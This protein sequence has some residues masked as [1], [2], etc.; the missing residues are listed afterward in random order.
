[1]NGIDIITDK[2]REGMHQGNMHACIRDVGRLAGGYLASGAITA[3]ELQVA[4]QLCRGLAINPDQAQR[5]WDESVGHGTNEPCSP[6]MSAFESVPLALDAPLADFGMIRAAKTELEKTKMRQVFDTH[7]ME[8]PE[9]PVGWHGGEALA[10]YVD[11]L[12]GPDEFV[13]FSAESYE[14][15]GRRVPSKGCYTMTAGQITDQLT[16]MPLAHV[17]GDWDESAG[18]WI[19]FN[20]LDGE[21]VSDRN[22]TDYRHA[23]VES[24]S[25]PI[26]DQWAI[27]NALELPIAAVVS[28]GKKSIHAIVKINARDKSEYR[29]RVAHLYDV[30][31][32]HG[33]EIDKQN[34]NC[35]R[36]SRLP[37]ATRNGNPQRLLSLAMGKHSWQ[38]W[39]DWVADAQ[40]DLPDVESWDVDDD[41]RP[42]PAP[43]L[44][45]GTLRE[46]HKMMIAGPSKAGKSFLLIQLC[47][48]AATGTKW[49]GRNVAK[50]KALYVNLELDKTS[51]NCRLFDIKHKLGLK[52]PKGNLDVWHLRGNAVSLDKLAPKLIR[53]ARDA[54]YS[55]IVIDPLYKVLT[56]DE[57]SNSEMAEFCNYFD[58]IAN[59]L[60]C[61][62]VYCHHHSKGKQGHKS[63]N[64]RSSGAGVF[65]RDPDAVMDLIELE[66]SESAQKVIQE[67]WLCD[68][69]TAWL[70]I[71][72]DG[73]RANFPQDDQQVY[74][75]LKPW[76]RDEY[77]ASGALQMMPADISAWRVSG[78]LREFAR[79]E[80]VNCFF[81][82]PVHEIETTG[83]LADCKEQ[84]EETPIERAQR[85]KRQA[86]E[87]QKQD[88]RAAWEIAMAT[89]EGDVHLSQMAEILGCAVKTAR[90]KA[91]TYGYTV[92]DGVIERKA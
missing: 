62:I 51:S 19:R 45:E 12:F 90:R 77:P 53:R 91:T 89:I 65:A 58:Q 37:G 9:L 3:P 39:E 30:C 80:N 72:A 46:G 7:Y 21:G 41:E 4:A 63:S 43:E 13:G 38:A 73:W 81:R 24:D 67:R 66:V 68:E 82:W 74:R 28:S 25:V 75:K 56:G 44:I 14:Q 40:D 18:A 49:L 16:R 11:A 6:E 42:I 35:S 17:I 20:P 55:L 83:I 85:L 52:I 33:L 34:R 78:T 61:A 50:G 84:G 32:A 15:D 69:L 70:D 59:S 36:L 31:Q 86:A 23:L 2:L 71:N 26:A 57:N 1:M 54:K 27:I 64:D 87:Q 48:A 8:R 22:V 76:A 60:N 88:D 10:K 47:V 79:F 92:S 29:E 5:K